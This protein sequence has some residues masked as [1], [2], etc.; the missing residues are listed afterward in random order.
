MKDS[1][2]GL[3]TR[4]HME[5]NCM[6]SYLAMQAVQFL[7]SKAYGDG[8][9]RE[10]NVTNVNPASGNLD[11][12]GKYYLGSHLATRHVNGQPLNDTSPEHLSSDCYF[13]HFHRLSG[14]TGSPDDGYFAIDV[15]LY[16]S[17]WGGTYRILKGNEFDYENEVSSDNDL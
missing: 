2:Q 15:A 17:G 14:G 8:P 4:I 7:T 11:P 3:D 13:Q 10:F 5:Q 1:C 6:W 9:V 12:A 16:S